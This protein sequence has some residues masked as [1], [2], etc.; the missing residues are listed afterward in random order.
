MKYKPE[1]KFREIGEDTFEKE[2]ERKQKDQDS[3]Q[4]SFDEVIHDYFQE[5]EIN[6]FHEEFRKETHRLDCYIPCCGWFVCEGK[7][8]G[9]KEIRNMVARRAIQAE[10]GKKWT[11]KQI[12]VKFSCTIDGDDELN[13]VLREFG[14][15][16]KDCMRHYENGSYR[17]ETVNDIMVYLRK[18]IMEGMFNILDENAAQ[19]CEEMQEQRNRLRLPRSFGARGGGGGRRKPPHHQNGC[20]ACEKGRKCG[21]RRKEVKDR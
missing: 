2:D 15:R 20:E 14:Q 19:R 7:V 6:E 21:E 10:C 11:S 12:L 9:T 16:C 5:T 1:L 3:W 4:Q 8:I 18:M 13:V 17:P